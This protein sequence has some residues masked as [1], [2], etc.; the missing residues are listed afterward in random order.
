MGQDEVV[1][2]NRQLVMGQD[3]LVMVARRGRDGVIARS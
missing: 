3:E 2:A 1:M